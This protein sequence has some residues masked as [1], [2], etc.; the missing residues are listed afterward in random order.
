MQKRVRSVHPAAGWWRVFLNDQRGREE[1]TFTAE[2]PGCTLNEASIEIPHTAWMLPEVHALADA[3]DLAVPEHLP[4]RQYTAWEPERPLYDFQRQGSAFILSTMGSLLAD[5]M[6]VGKSSQAIV[7]A[8]CVRR[9]NAGKPVIIVAPLNVRGTWLRELDAL[10]AISSKDQFCALQS[11]NLND[12]SFRLDA[13]YYFIHFDIA[14][15]WWPKLLELKR[16]G[17]EPCM[18]I[19]DEAHLLRNSRTH[20]S[21]GALLIAGT[22]HQ[23]TLLTGTPLDNKPS[24]LWF[25][26]T[27]ATG[28][29]TW[30]SPLDFRKRYAGAYPTGYGNAWHDGELTRTDE[31]KARLRPFYLRR[32]ADE[33]GLELPAL[34]R[35]TQLCELGMY[36]GEHAD[37]LRG[38]P[39]IDVVRAVADGVMSDHVLYM[40]SRLRQITSAAKVSATV[41]LVR[42]AVAQGEQ[43]VVFTWARESAHEIAKLLYSVP[44]SVVTGEHAQK[45]RDDRI[46]GFQ[47]GNAKVLIATLGA[48]SVGVTLHA[49]RIVVMHDLDWVLSSMLQAE[50]RIHRIGQKR[51]CQSI[52]MLAERS[53]D[54]L[55]APILLRKAE[56]M[57]GILDIEAGATLARDV[58]LSELCGREAV[59]EQIDRVM[60][61]W[62]AA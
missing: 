37:V 40:L 59:D 46:D 52:W 60:R 9:A 36:T 11:R 56:L 22:C 30:G 16:R 31:L 23:R 26:L 20:R 48:L 7:A 6:G 12:A 27:I 13:H 49:A 45:R 35:S 58:G 55:I 29:R 25:P 28:A 51:A 15:A 1:A 2:L 34:T 42:N 3:L 24:D 17:R 19:V 57:K 39:M 32:T 8:E 61:V 54:T 21:K 62:G 10:G 44:H 33:V 41:E 18:A 4:W 5:E 38:A 43:V 14:Q 53:I 50:K 47:A